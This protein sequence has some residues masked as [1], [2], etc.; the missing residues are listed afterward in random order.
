[1]QFEGGG[2]YMGSEGVQAH[3]GFPALDPTGVR[4][5]PSIGR[6]CSFSDTFQL[7]F[8]TESEVGIKNMIVLLSLKSLRTKYANGTYREAESTLQRK[9]TTA[10]GIQAGTTQ[11]DIR[12][13]IASIRISVTHLDGI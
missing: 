13:L 2:Y 9:V 1:M 10:G 8:L 6:G 12:I 11:T 5:R 3:T 7:C 4:F